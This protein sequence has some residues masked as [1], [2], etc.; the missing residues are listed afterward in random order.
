MACHRL[1]TASRNVLSLVVHADSCSFI[2]ISRAISTLLWI[3]DVSISKGMRES[4]LHTVITGALSRDLAEKWYAL[5]NHSYFSE[6][7]YLIDESGHAGGWQNRYWGG[8]MYDA[9]LSVKRKYDPNDVFGAGTASAMSL[10]IVI[11]GKCKTS[12]QCSVNFIF[13]A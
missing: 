8:E 10:M 6:S 4:I 11:L 13:K 3:Q 12:K 5:G 2:K 7:A 9:F 1:R